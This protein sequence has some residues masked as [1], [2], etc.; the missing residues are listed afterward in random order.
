MRFLLV[1]LIAV[2]LPVASAEA[3]PADDQ[4]RPSSSSPQRSAPDFLFQTPDGSFGVRGS[5]V[6]A[7]AGSDWYDFV[8]DH[9]TLENRDFNAP[10]FGVDLGIT[11]T[12]RVDAVIGFDFSQSTTGSEYRDFVDN[13]RL[14]ITQQTR[15]REMNLSGGVRLALTERGREVGSFAWVPRTVVPYVGAGG[16]M[17]WFDVNQTGDFVDF[18][19]NSIF[20]DVFRSR[21]WAPSAHVFGGVDIRVYRRLFLT[22]DG[23]YLWA[24]GDLGSDWIDFDPI[25]LT[26]LRLAA[27]INVVF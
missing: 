12:P 14:P 7:R 3:S 19:D 6:F 16:G 23:R 1:V 2:S 10:A 21:G 18:V 27:G 17:L 25:D 13:N 9:L 8:T 4:N 24:A 15:L 20:T 11:I 22:L 5:W 26:G